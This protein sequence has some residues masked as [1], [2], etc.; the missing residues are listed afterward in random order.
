MLLNLLN[1]YLINLVMGSADSDIIRT[2]LSI[3]KI[4]VM[5]FISKFVSYIQSQYSNNE[6]KHFKIL[7]SLNIAI[8]A[9]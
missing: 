6:L 7:L 3:V 5:N 4:T 2:V 8:D 9:L 1:N